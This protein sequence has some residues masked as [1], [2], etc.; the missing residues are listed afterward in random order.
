MIAENPQLTNQKV[1]KIRAFLKVGYRKSP[2]RLIRHGKSVT[3][4]PTQYNKYALIELIENMMSQKEEIDK[5]RFSLLYGAITSNSKTESNDST[6]NVVREDTD[7]RKNKKD[8]E[9]Q[10]EDETEDSIKRDDD[11]KAA[12]Q[13]ESRIKRILFGQK[14]VSTLQIML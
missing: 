3:E 2:L 14:K 8:P 7:E 9:Q 12:L 6:D 5:K 1:L 10:S 11:E 13:K 4:N